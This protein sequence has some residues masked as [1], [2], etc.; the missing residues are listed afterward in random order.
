MLEPFIITTIVGEPQES[1]AAIIPK[2]A[3]PGK[4]S[5]QHTQ[6]ERNVVR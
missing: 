6:G 3:S 5:R 2:M 4:M 1:H